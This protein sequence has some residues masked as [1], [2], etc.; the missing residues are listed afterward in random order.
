MCKRSHSSSAYTSTYSKV[1]NCKISL[2]S[3]HQQLRSAPGACRLPFQAY[4]YI[5]QPPG[6]RIKNTW[7]PLLSSDKP[8]RFQYAL[9][10][11]R[12]RAHNSTAEVDRAAER[13]VAGRLSL[14]LWKVGS[15]SA[16]LSLKAVKGPGQGQ[17]SPELGGYRSESSAWWPYWIG[18]II[19]SI[20]TS[21]V[22]DQLSP[23]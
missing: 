11:T 7:H 2:C 1:K 4:R 20:V 10:R 17:R 22:T 16:V 12:T 6:L 15:T 9:S 5:S 3:F 13:P 18:R 14:L 23:L 8:S 19:M 21:S